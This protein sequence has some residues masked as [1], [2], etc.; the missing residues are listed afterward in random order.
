MAAAG[1]TC[2]E[3][4]DHGQYDGTLDGGIKLRLAHSKVSTVSESDV[5]ICLLWYNR[6]A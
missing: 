4:Q 3:D 6:G 5:N 2:C 1:G